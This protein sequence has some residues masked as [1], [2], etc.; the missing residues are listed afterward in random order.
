M[1]ST[2]PSVKRLPQTMGFGFR[3][4]SRRTSKVAETR[5]HLSA[6]P[7]LEELQA[8]AQSRGSEEDEAQTGCLS[9][10]VHSCMLPLSYQPESSDVV[11]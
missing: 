8:P 7:I 4:T 6:G 9:L 3:D 10:F 1:Q 2:S 11:H 5:W